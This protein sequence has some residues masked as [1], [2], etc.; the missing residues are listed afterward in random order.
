MPAP[1]LK[2]TGEIS[3]LAL[4]GTS[5]FLTS[6]IG[7]QGQTVA[8]PT[9]TVPRLINFGGVLKGHNRQPLAGV[10]GV[11]FSLYKDQEGGVPIWKENQNLQLDAEGR[12]TTLLGSTQ[13]SGLPMDL[14]ASGEWRRLGVQAQ[15]PGEEEQPRILLVSVPYALK[16]GDADTI[17]GKP[18]SA[19]VLNEPGTRLGLRPAEKSI[20]TLVPT[21]QGFASGGGSIV[22]NGVGTSMT[23]T[24]SD[25]VGIGTASPATPLEVDGAGEVLRL[26]STGNT[27][28]SLMSSGTGHQN[29]SL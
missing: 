1:S 8:P 25:N 14:F 4:I 26:N 6:I 11:T 17:G 12:Y 13:A 3:R 7:T 10:V 15:L 24:S 28:L 19:F 5:L 29:R 2:A 9:V 27:M 23:I 16:A 20:N 22:D 18:V 21:V